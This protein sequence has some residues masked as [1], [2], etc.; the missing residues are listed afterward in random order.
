[1]I[2][3]NLQFLR[4]AHGYSQEEVAERIGVSRQAVHDA[5]RK[6]E[7]TLTDM[8]GKLRL[9]EKYRRLHRAVALSQD[10]LERGDAGAARRILEEMQKEGVYGV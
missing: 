8:E 7:K 4:R 3:E 5:L 1:M 10:A 9:V 6:A 2:H